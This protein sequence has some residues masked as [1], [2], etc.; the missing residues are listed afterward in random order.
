MPPLHFFIAAIKFL[1]LQGKVIHEI[2]N[3]K[4]NS[5]IINKYLP[6]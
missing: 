5:N 4:M 2:S 1:W 3:L 6:V